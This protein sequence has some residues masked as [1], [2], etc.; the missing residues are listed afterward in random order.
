MHKYGY[1]AAEV[2][3]RVKEV[4]NVDPIELERPD[5]TFKTSMTEINPETRRAIKK[6][7][8]K[9][10]YEKDPN[11]MPR[12]AG[13]IIEVE[14][15]DK[16]KATELLGREKDTFK[17]TRKVE[18]DVTGRMAEVLLES[19]RTAESHIKDINN[20]DIINVKALPMPEEV[21]ESYNSEE[22]SN[23]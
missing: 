20:P 18:H 23:E 19:K 12:L 1:D 7:R 10:F 6:F 9:N 14:F 5:G 3:E 15:W 11:G 13:Q 21:T 16:L 17:E 8:A 22:E 4:S 2:V